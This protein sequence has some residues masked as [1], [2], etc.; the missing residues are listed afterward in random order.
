MIELYKRYTF[1]MPQ[2]TISDT[3]IAL[4]EYRITIQAVQFGEWLKLNS[5]PGM[6]RLPLLPIDWQWVW[7]VPTG[8]YRGTFPK[9]VRAYYYKEYG[10]KCPDTFIQEI[11]E[12]ARSHAADGITYDFEF[13]NRIDW[14]AGD[15]GDLN[16]CI[17]RS[18]PDAIDM[19]HDHEARAVRFYNVNNK[20]IGRAFV[21][22]VEDD[23]RVVFNGY[24]FE[25]NATLTIV[26]VAALWLNTSYKR[27][28]LTN[29]GDGSG[30]L[31]INNST[32]Y[33]L[34]A[35]ERINTIDDHDL[36]WPEPY[37]ETCYNCG[38]SLSEDAIYWAP[39][40]EAYCDNCFSNFFTSCDGCYEYYPIEEV[41]YDEKRDGYYCQ[42]C[43][44]A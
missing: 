26:R 9:R 28:T 32:G 15:Y 1:T 31:W 4:I 3:G 30:M 16:S 17:L 13:V 11:G 10:L 37:Q 2:G 33:L 34:G 20:G 8:E 18:R 44:V 21:V 7:L 25:G 36:D 42:N 35:K 38:R 22:D 29:N 41:N 14:R 19:L 5:Q 23:L 43:Q 39:D 24:G 40:N 12:I 6:W 27:I